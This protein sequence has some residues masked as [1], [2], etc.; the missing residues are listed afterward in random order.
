M[1]AGTVLLSIFQTDKGEPTLTKTCNLILD[2]PETSCHPINFSGPGHF[3]FTGYL[4]GFGATKDTTY[5]N[6]PVPGPSPPFPPSVIT[7]GN[8]YVIAQLPCLIPTGLGPQTV[9][10]A[11]CSDDTTLEYYQT[12]PKGD[13]GQCPLGFFVVIT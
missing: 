11:L 3:T 2:L 10:G 5:N 9:S 4:T 1:Y 13:K 6:Q 12:G 7:P 8:S